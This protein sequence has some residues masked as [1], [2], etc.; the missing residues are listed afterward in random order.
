M[1]FIEGLGLDQI[2]KEVRT[3][4][5]QS[6]ISSSMTPG[7]LY[8]RRRDLTSSD[9]TRSSQSDS[10]DRC[11]E[12]RSARDLRTSVDVDA[13]LETSLG[14]ASFG[15]LSDF[16]A[17]ADPGVKAI[18]SAPTRDRIAVFLMAALL[19]VAIVP[20]AVTRLL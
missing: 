15:P 7:P 16:S 11:P 6:A 8:V 13:T 3:K 20:M 1:Q 14:R 19:S 10:G 9:T 5:K 18:S 2:L 17:A 12:E 4:Q